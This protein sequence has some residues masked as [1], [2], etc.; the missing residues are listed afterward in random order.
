MTSLS[1]IC[2]RIKVMRGRMRGL[3]RIGATKEPSCHL[4]LDAEAILAGPFTTYEAAEA[5][6]RAGGFPKRAYITSFRVPEKEESKKPSLL[7]SL[8]GGDR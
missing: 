6:L 3:T 1:F 2:L 8:L 5:V 7:R 4:S